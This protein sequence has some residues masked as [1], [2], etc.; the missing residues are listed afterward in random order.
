VAAAPSRRTCTQA[1]V[2]K[3]PERTSPEKR[4]AGK[5]LMGYALSQGAD[6]EI[7]LTSGG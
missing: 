6:F 4:T 1:A 5:N 3:T 2:Q 7:E